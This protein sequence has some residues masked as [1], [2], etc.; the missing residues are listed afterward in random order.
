MDGLIC[1]RRSAAV[2]R[3][4]ERVC[5]LSGQGRWRT[6]PYVDYTWP[7]SVWTNLFISVLDHMQYTNHIILLFIVLFLIG[8]VTDGNKSL[9]SSMT[10]MLE[11]FCSFI[12]SGNINKKLSRI[13][14]LSSKVKSCSPKQIHM[15]HYSQFLEMCPITNNKPFAS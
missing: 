9:E 15:K 5:P 4:P 1:G 2:S 3:R 13:L 11:Y 7:D 14:D 12:K 8:S 10:S 6:M